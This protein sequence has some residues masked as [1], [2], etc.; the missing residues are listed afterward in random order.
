MTFPKALSNLLAMEE[1]SFPMILAFAAPLFVAS[2]ALEWWLVAKGRAKGRYD[3]RDGI[4]SMTMGLGNLISD[5]LMGAVS[6]ALLMWVWQ[7]RIFDLGTSL[8]VILL[9]F[10]AG[11]FI[12]YWK[13][14]A[15]HRIRWFWSAHVVHHSSEHYNLTTALRQPWNNH[16]TG[17]VLLSSPLVILG[18]HPALVGFAAALN[19][20]YQFWIHTEAID[21][22]PGGFEAVFNTPSH[23]RVHHATNPDY[24]DR[25]YAG[26]LIIW[27]KLFGTFEPEGSEPIAYGTVKPI[28][29]YN[30][31]KIAFA[32]LAQILRDASAPKLSLSQRLAYIFAPPGWSHDG[33][34]QTSD[35]IRDAARRDRKTGAAGASSAPSGSQ[36]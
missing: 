9:A 32:E 22:M 26:T 29:T 1:P 16:F 4:S 3:W 17:H 31:L 20:L 6:L 19:L 14:R 21:R 8:P 35:Q 34:R 23:H 5:I 36:A 33:S 2:V 15:A 24:L 28:N 18:F 13:H 10:V 27:D 11:D 12:Y 7:F 25:N 30:P